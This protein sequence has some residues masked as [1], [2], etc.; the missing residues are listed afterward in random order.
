MKRLWNKNLQQHSLIRLI[1]RQ[2]NIIPNKNRK[3]PSGIITGKAEAS[4]SG[5]QK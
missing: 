3:H 5:L 1:Q 4:E 2:N